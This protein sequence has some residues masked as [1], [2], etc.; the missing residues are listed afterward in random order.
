MKDKNIIKNFRSESDWIMKLDKVKN[1]VIQK[2]LNVISETQ[3]K[4][5]QDLRCFKQV[6]RIEKD[7]IVKI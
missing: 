6:I 4:D 1:K 5:Q 7:K 3:K 2:K